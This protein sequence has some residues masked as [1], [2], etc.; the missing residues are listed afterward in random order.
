MCPYNMEEVVGHF[1][2]PDACTPGHYVKLKL[3]VKAL[4]K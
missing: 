3:E 1:G 2:K 4:P